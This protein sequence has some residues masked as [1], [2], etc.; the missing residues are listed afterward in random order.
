[1]DFVLPRVY[2]F[3]KRNRR[4]VKP[5]KAL[6]LFFPKLKTGLLLLLGQK[7]AFTLPVKSYTESQTWYHQAE[8][9]QNFQLNLKYI[10]PPQ[11]IQRGAVDTLNGEL[12]WKF[13]D[14]QQRQI[15][16]N[17][18]MTIPQG[19]VI[20]DGFVVSPD[21]TL[22]TDFS[23]I[24]D[25]QIIDHPLLSSRKLIPPKYIRGKSAVLAAHGG[26]GYYHWMFEVLPR[27][28]LI[29]QAGIEWTQIDKF[30]VNSCITQFQIDS[31]KTLGIPRS[32]IVECHWHPHIISDCL[33]V[34]SIPDYVSPWV[35]DFL[36]SNF[37]KNPIPAKPEKRLYISRSRAAH[38]RVVNEEEVVEVLKKYF[39]Q[40]VY[41][42][43]YSVEAQ[44]KLMSQ[45]EL[46]VAPHGAG[47]TNLV[48][49][50]PGA[51]LIELIYPLSVKKLFWS[52]S[53]LMQLNYYYLFAQGNPPPEGEE[54]YLNS[55]DMLIDVEKLE[56][57]LNKIP[58]A[59]DV[60][61]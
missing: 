53:S 42:E 48:F 60:T 13:K 59:L 5:L 30:I 33:I 56:R 50:A 31:L 34:P 21:A 14:K 23:I 29:R 28:E 6:W 24:P 9:K 51:T 3:I 57:L 54:S 16:E 61:T 45:A 18:V 15:R 10:H 20:D 47:L 11:A 7:N 1:M 46:I 37:L 40:C 25:T 49:C 58:V 12:Y 4:W 43:E 17:I 35:C 8:N 36:R 52:I 41:L 26:R 55:D 44:A 32:K 19:R 27:L 39:F 2:K 22:L 38:R